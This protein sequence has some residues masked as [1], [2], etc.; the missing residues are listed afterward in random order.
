MTIRPGDTFA[1]APSSGH[2]GWLVRVTRASPNSIEVTVVLG[3]RRGK[4]SRFRLSRP[5]F[6][7][8]ARSVRS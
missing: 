8:V 1:L 3:Q 7:R 4:S 2:A 6:E 5:L